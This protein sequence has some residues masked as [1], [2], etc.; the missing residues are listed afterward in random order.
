MPNSLR[1]KLLGCCALEGQHRNVTSLWIA[2]RTGHPST[3][4]FDPAVEI[5]WKLNPDREDARLVRQEV[6]GEN[7]GKQENHCNNR[8]GKCNACQ[9]ANTGSDA[10]KTMARKQA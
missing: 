9:K 7:E 5:R 1:D 6:L 4:G 10:C 3:P 8:H 2:A